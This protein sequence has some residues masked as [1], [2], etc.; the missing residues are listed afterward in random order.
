MGAIKG[1]FLVIVSVLLF[2]SI[3]SSVLSL[4][5]TSSLNYKNLQRESKEIVKGLLE[6]EVNFSSTFDEAYPLIQS[7]CQNNSEY[8]LNSE[9]FTFT[10]SC[11]SALEGKT[12]LIENGVDSLI[13]G[14]YYKEYTCEFIDCFKE[15]ELPL[16]VFSMK[17]YTFFNN[18]FKISLLI[19]SLLLLS[20]F[21]LMEKKTNLFILAGILTIISSLLFFKITDLINL[22]PEKT[23]SQVIGLFFSSSFSISIK[24]LIIGIIL[25][26]TGIVLKIFKVGFSI[27]D[28]ISK[29]KRP[30]VKKPLNKPSKKDVKTAKGKLK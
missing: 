7:Y 5:L 27:S 22:L 13:K 9:G 20:A 25:L 10:L 3:F 1:F 28:V 11:T 4:T 23:I 12:A 15:G 2:L 26:I 30:E 24:I 16:F 6:E 29:F 18:I 19:V 8:V 14:I 17:S 21:L